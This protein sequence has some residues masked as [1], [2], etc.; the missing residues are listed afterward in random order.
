MTSPLG[1]ESSEHARFTVSLDAT[2]G[3]E[4]KANMVQ[5]KYL[6][7]QPPEEHFERLRPYREALLEMA[8]A[9]RPGGPEY[10]A[11]HRAVLALDD[12]AGTVMNRPAFFHSGGHSTP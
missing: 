2:A 8:Q 4:H 10:L 7:L 12:A 1:Q 3:I 9:F 11:L 6:G 5:K